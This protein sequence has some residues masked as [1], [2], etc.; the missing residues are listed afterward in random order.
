[1]K[2]L[3]ILSLVVFVTM[4]MFSFGQN[5][6]KKEKISFPKGSLSYA[7]SKAVNYSFTK[8]TGTYTNLTNAVSLNNG[9]AWD[10]PSYDV[11]IPFLFTIN[12]VPV[13]SLSFDGYG[14]MLVANSSVAYVYEI[15]LPFEMDILDRGYIDEFSLSPLSYKVEG[16][17]GNRILK[18]EW[19]NVGSYEEYYELNSLDMYINFQLWLYESNHN[20]E[21]HF[22][23]SM[24]DQPHYFY[25]G[26]EP[27]VGILTFDDYNEILSNVHLLNG[28]P[29]NPQFITGNVDL[30]TETYI[31]TGTPANGTIYRFS[32][33]LA[34]IETIDINSN[35]SVY[36]NPVN[37]LLNI[38]QKNNLSS[39]SLTMFDITGRVVK[40]VQTDKHISIIDVSDLPQ[41]MYFLKC[42]A[43][44]DNRIK[45][46]IVR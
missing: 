12:N 32:N 38:E 2:K 40:T 31:L 4:S 46:N 36:P 45:I 13:T 10:D 26:D 41:G 19:N 23:P 5:V 7:N 27:M 14:S 37:N 24:I 3:S 34:N 1:M 20:I 17:T 43:S 9:E 29:D 18:I 22:G 15:I 6:S 39:L 8:S 28:D 44:P 33:V 35:I 11:P 42:N 30:E 16:T 25:F 21:V